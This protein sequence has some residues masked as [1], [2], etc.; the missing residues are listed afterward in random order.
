MLVESSKSLH[1]ALQNRGLKSSSY[2]KRLSKLASNL[3][4][5][6]RLSLTG[7][8]V[9]SIVAVASQQMVYAAIPVTA[10]LSLSFAN[11][12]RL[13][14]Q[15]KKIEQM[16]QSLHC[17]IEL[18]PNARRYSEVE[19]LT[20]KLSEKTLKLEQAIQVTD[21]KLSNLSQQFKTIPGS[22]AIAQ[23]EETNS[24]IEQRLNQL[25]SFI[26]TVDLVSIKHTISSIKEQFVILETTSF[27]SLNQRVAEL[28]TDLD[29]QQSQLSQKYEKLQL[30]YQSVS[31]LASDIGKLKLEQ[32]QQIH[33]NKT[34]IQQLEQK[35]EKYQEQVDDW[36]AEA[37][38]LS[39]QCKTL[40][41]A[42][43]EVIRKMS[44]HPLDD[45]EQSVYACLQANLPQQ[46]ILIQYDAGTGRDNSK[47][48]DFIVVMKNCIIAI[49]AKCYQGLIKAKGD[50]R[51]TNWICQKAGSEVTVMACSGIN[52]YQQ[53]KSYI[54][55]I[56][57]RVE[58]GQFN[59]SYRRIPI[60]GIVLFPSRAEIATNIE[61]NL[62]N[63]YRVTTLDKLP[64]VICSIENKEL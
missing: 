37:E 43:W 57:S 59:S 62:G 3:E 17:K 63:F 2:L 5:A 11:R 34:Y 35:L 54:N 51:N 19:T 10:A 25:V 42:N 52:P 24:S 50:P 21:N 7:S 55:G 23:L 36:Q 4:A 20:N 38:N 32:K 14:Q 58:R 41:Q 9:G 64:K 29:L 47:F 33:G 6:E 1:S 44:E 40:N 39:H 48:V 46:E 18:L 56:K 15:N 30:R 31:F 45:F 49:E 28:Q 61:S 16:V 13:Q 22:Q 27:A 26:E 53:L 60:Y 12:Q 8:A